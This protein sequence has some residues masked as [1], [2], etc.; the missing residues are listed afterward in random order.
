M[1]VQ[2]IHDITKIDKWFLWKIQ[3]IIEKEKGLGDKGCLLYP[4]RSFKMVDT[5]AGEF[6]AE[7]PYFYSSAGG[8]NEAE[9]YLAERSAK[10]RYWFLAPA[11][12]ALVRELNLTTRAS[13][14]SAR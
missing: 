8:D 6:S 9:E 7:T 1:S 2:E 4:P 3:G 14:A 11:Q 10:R 5:S 12:S 13:N